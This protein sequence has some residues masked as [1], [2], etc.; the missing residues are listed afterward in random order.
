MS[1]VG[2]TR[3]QLLQAGAAASLLAATGGVDSA[4][5][6][7]RPNVV[8][9]VMDTLRAD[10]VFSRQIHTPNI[11]S[12][13]R[14]G[15]TF[16]N[17]FPE[18][19]PTVPARNSIL[20][21]KR[22]FP[23]R[24]WHDYRGLIDQPGWSPLDDVSQTF[25]SALNRAGYWTGYA[26]DNPFIGFS[27][28][29]EPLRRSFDRFAAT[30]GQLGVSLPPSSVSDRELRHWIH[31]R[32]DDPAIRRRVRKYMANG[33][34]VHDESSS[35]AARV[36][37]DGARMV[38][39]APADRPFAVVVDT[40]QPHE[41]WTPPR[42]YLDLYARSRWSRE[43]S[44]PLYA[45]V[46]SY[47]PRGERHAYLRRMRSL[48]AAELTMTDHWL[49]VFLD[50]LRKTGR[51]RNT[52][53]VLVGDHGIYLGEHGWTGKIST[54]L[55]PELIRVPLIVVDPKRRKAGKRSEYFAST[56][57]VGPTLLSMAGVKAPRPMTGT[58]LSRTFGGRKLPHRPY[59]YGG[60][61]DNFYIRSHK[62]ALTA[63]NRPSDF[64]LYDLEHDRGE[65]HN[66]AGRHPR[67]AR[68]LYGTVLRRAGGR[69]PFYDD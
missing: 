52:A 55:H 21:G 29:Y 51:H 1:E 54:S 62:W 5:A 45:A 64:R 40:F 50:R 20:S 32:I 33:H 16:T 56:H 67:K 18:A 4:F 59:A 6:A 63:T 34:Y 30:G 47:L 65:A 17:V 37:G 14:A 31:P 41:P 26:T 48:Y 28:P 10:Y 12:L 46:T 25:T 22:G 24:G 7:S 57:D 3:R 38:E 58:D 23:F 44:F 13:A 36:V 39:D 69:L 66:L 68:E 53:I 15:V 35:F 49:G 9:I 27:A 11:D 43:P 8:L 2:S 61:R 60:Y 19:M 42:K